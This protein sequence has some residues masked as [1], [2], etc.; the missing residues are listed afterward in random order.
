MIIVSL[1]SLAW[2]GYGESKTY[3]HTIVE[4]QTLDSAARSH[5]IR[6]GSTI[7][8][9]SIHRYNGRVDFV[10]EDEAAW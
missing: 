5:R 3:Y 9:G 1:A 7:E 4:L 6:V 2:M 10:F 8:P